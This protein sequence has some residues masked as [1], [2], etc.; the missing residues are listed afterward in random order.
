M[1]FPDRCGL[2]AAVLFQRT[3][4]EPIGESS[5]ETGF[6]GSLRAIANGSSNG[7]EFSSFAATYFYNLQEGEKGT[8]SSKNHKGAFYEKDY[9]RIISTSSCCHF[10]TIAAI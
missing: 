4:S 9:K 3:R 10:C 7:G 1:G 2:L 5:L 6:E 8:D